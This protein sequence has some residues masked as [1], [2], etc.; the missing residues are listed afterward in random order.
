[1]QFG[2]GTFEHRAGSVGGVVRQKSITIK[3]C[4]VTY[5]QAVCFVV[6]FF[7]DKHQILFQL[8]EEKRAGRRLELVYEFYYYME[9]ILTIQL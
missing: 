5:L 9:A 8:E 1:M 2:A 3:A 4:N 6:L 7:T